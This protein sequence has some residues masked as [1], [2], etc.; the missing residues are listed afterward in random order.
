MEKPQNS[1]QHEHWQL[2]VAISKYLSLAPLE[3]L[4]SMGGILLSQCLSQWSPKLFLV[5]RTKC[6]AD[7]QCS[8]GHFAIW[9]T[10][11]SA[12]YFMYFCLPNSSSML[13]TGG[14]NVRQCLN[15][16]PDISKSCRTCPACPAY[17]AITGLSKWNRMPEWPVFQTR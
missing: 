3:G 12:G 4:Y 5:C 1:I 13:T 8:A 10:K 11:L 14:Q 17:L 9:Y 16:L 15:S 2:S 7:I 6:P